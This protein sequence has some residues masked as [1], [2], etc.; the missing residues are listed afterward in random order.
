MTLHFSLELNL[1]SNIETTRQ[2]Y[3][4]FFTKQLP[5]IIFKQLLTSSIKTHT[6]LLC[7]PLLQV[8]YFITKE[9]LD[10]KTLITSFCPDSVLTIST[11]Y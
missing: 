6:F 2:G 1:R 9:D 10:E 7:V 11:D 4:L 8:Y 3:T 5:E